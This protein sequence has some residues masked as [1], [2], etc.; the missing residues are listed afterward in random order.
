MNDNPALQILERLQRL[1]GIVGRFSVYSSRFPQYVKLAATHK[2]ADAYIKEFG[3]KTPHSV[4]VV[5]VVEERMNA[6]STALANGDMDT[7]NAISRECSGI[8]YGQLK[9]K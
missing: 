6:A 4:S 5:E 9:R 3:V 7:Y 8:T 2:D 1:E